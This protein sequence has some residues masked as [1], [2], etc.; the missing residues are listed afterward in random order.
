MQSSSG[1]QAKR[2]GDHGVFTLMYEWGKF[3][4]RKLMKLISDCLYVRVSGNLQSS[5]NCSLHLPDMVR[6]Q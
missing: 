5:S 4:I 1:V 2:G 3:R 6:P